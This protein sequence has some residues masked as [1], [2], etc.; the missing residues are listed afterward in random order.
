MIVAGAAAGLGYGAHGVWSWHRRGEGFAAGDVHGH[1]FPFSVAAVRRSAM[2]YLDQ[3]EILRHDS[4]PHFLAEKPPGRLLLLTYCLTGDLPASRNAVRDAF[5]RSGYRVIGA[6]LAGVAKEE[7]AAK[8]GIEARTIA[9]Y[10][11]Q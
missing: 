2:D 10:L 9:S 8:S 11:H 7:L 5:E 4:W 6:A 3:A 1:P